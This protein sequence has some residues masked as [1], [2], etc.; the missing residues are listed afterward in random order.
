MAFTAPAIVAEVAAAPVAVAVAVAEVAVAPGPVVPDP[1]V[2]AIESL[3]NIARDAGMEWVLTD[4]DKARAVQEQIAA[5]PRPVH[6]PRILPTMVLPD[7]GPL[8]LVETRRDLAQW[9]LPFDAAEPAPA[10]VESV[11]AEAASV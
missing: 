11:T 5:E 1:Y 7:D 4:A 2:L 9:A 6:V 3:Q 8:V 10:V